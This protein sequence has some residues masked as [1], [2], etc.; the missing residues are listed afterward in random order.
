MSKYEQ[1]ADRIIEDFSHG[2]KLGEKST[3]RLLHL[4]RALACAVDDLNA[5]RQR[6]LEGHA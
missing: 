1:A 2:H 4:V 6:Q 5:E 3:E